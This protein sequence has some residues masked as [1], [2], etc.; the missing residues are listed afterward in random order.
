[1]MSCQ[2]KLIML[3]YGIVAGIGAGITYSLNPILWLGWL[4]IVLA[5]AIPMGAWL[6]DRDWEK[7]H[8]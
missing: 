8:R 1:M 5:G 6:A 3:A 7:G 4:V 2:T